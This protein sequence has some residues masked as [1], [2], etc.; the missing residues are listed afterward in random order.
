[1]PVDSKTLDI[2]V[3]VTFRIVFNLLL[4]RARYFLVK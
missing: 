3:A 1:M 2:K 4:N